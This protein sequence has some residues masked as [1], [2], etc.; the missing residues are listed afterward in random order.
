MKVLIKL[1]EQ[2]KKQEVTTQE[3]LII[4]SDTLLGETDMWSSL[5][6][7]LMPMVA[8]HFLPLVFAVKI[9]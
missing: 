5:L 2:E 1:C 9:A 4:S 3:L 8:F 6:N 7:T